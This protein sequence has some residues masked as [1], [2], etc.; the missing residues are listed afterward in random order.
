[1]T[2]PVLTLLSQIEREIGELPGSRLDPAPAGAALDEKL[3]E[4]LGRPVPAGVAAFMRAYDGG[5]FGPTEPEPEKSNA[6]GP[7]AEPEFGLTVKLMS[8]DDS[9]RLRLQGAEV[10][11]GLWPIARQGGHIIALDADA[12]SHGEWPVVQL[13]DRSFD[14][15]GTSLLRF[16]T[17]LCVEMRLGGSPDRHIE[18]ARERARRDPHLCEHWMSLAEALSRAG[19]RS[20]AGAVLN[21]GLGC[22]D[23]VG[24]ALLAA[25]G[26]EAIAEG[27]L[28]RARGALEDALA[29][30]PLTARDDDARLDAA[31]H[32]LAI[33]NQTGDLTLAQRCQSVLKDS[34]AATAG[35]WRAEAARCFADDDQRRG[36]TA[37]AAVE[38]LVP[39][40]S[41]AA[42]MRKGGPGL[43][44]GLS[45][46]RAARRA[47]EAGEFDRSLQTMKQ[48]V[49]ACNDLSIL[50]SHL[51][52]LLNGFHSEEAVAEAR[53]SARLNPE[54]IE[55]W[56]ELG[57]AN[58]E[59]RGFE[60]A[61]TAY[62]EAI[63]RD[64]GYALLYGK[65]A[66]ALLE[67]GRRIDALDTI[68]RGAEV[69]GEG[70]FLA[71]IRGDIL[72][73]MDRH[74]EAAEAYDQALMFEPEDHWALHQ[75]AVEH[76]AANN[77]AR[78]QVLFLSAIEHDHDGCHQTLV[79][80]AQLLQKL[81]RIGDAVRLYRRAVAAVPAE[82][83]WRQWLRDA[84]KE[85]SAAPN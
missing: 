9:M 84:E 56:R 24:P 55:A 61:V 48:S 20:E 19:T 35:F 17:V 80:Y 39:G 40:D 29:C 65:K 46:A 79:D 62:D 5:H 77:H 8:F 33:A 7:S 22:A 34:V 71:A 59:R 78:A 64:P 41:D 16:L 13:V 74:G 57:D 11:R 30:E 53:E 23:P 45:L 82:T 72:A 73:A 75:A 67:Q 69:G 63:A 68:N 60:A 83:E 49:A 4:A 70:F 52:E 44:T 50:R 12:P 36:E 10:L 27:E 43:K 15:L 32:L 47:Q 31:A 38:A 25:L 26:F 37:L 81:G 1:V 76:A 14:R 51:A 58:L 54:S 66:Q 6:T 42:R 2:D 18:L 3:A 21:E 28:T 85:L